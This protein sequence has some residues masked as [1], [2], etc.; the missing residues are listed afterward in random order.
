[1]VWCVSD[2]LKPSP[3]SQKTS[4]CV[5]IA[6]QKQGRPSFEIRVQSQD[7]C[8]FWGLRVLAFPFVR[9]YVSKHAYASSF[10]R[11][12]VHSFSRIRIYTF[13]NFHLLSFRFDCLHIFPSSRPP[14][15]S[16]DAFANLHFPYFRKDVN[17]N[18]RAVTFSYL[19]LRIYAFTHSSICVAPARRKII[20]ISEGRSVYSN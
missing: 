12:G 10:F 5:G 16:Y 7:L 9:K 13:T 3:K 2:K 15:C 1:M 6:Y 11:F 17:A 4:D 19:H 14:I 8:F 18:V 20:F